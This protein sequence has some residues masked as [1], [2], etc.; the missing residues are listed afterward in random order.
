MTTGSEKYVFLMPVETDE[1]RDPGSAAGASAWVVSIAGPTPGSTTA[2][3]HENLIV[4][5]DGAEARDGDAM[6]A[7]V[8]DFFGRMRETGLPGVLDAQEIRGWQ[9]TPL[10]FC[11]L[12]TEAIADDLPDVDDPDFR[13]DD[14]ENHHLAPLR[15]AMVDACPEFSGEPAPSFD[16]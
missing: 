9:D 15:E 7:A 16:A 10:D 8:T 11:C 14:F 12:L 3:N 2:R 5:S 1:S 13:D 6:E 4:H